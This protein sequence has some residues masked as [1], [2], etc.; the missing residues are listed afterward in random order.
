MSIKSG[1]DCILILSLLTQMAISMDTIFISKKCKNTLDT[2]IYKFKENTLHSS[3]TPLFFFFLSS[4][5]VSFLRR[6]GKIN[7]GP[8]QSVMIQEVDDSL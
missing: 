5:G 1:G 7:V 4:L 8:D 2:D 6:V 3:P